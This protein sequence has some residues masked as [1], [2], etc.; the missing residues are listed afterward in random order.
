MNCISPEKYTVSEQALL[1][2]AE[3]IDHSKR[4]D[5]QKMTDFVVLES[6]Y[7]LS[8]AIRAAQCNEDWVDIEH[9]YHWSFQVQSWYD[10]LAVSLQE[11]DPS[12]SLRKGSSAAQA[13]ATVEPLVRD[14]KQALEVL[15]KGEES[16]RLR[17]TDEY[18]RSVSTRIATRI[19]NLFPSFVWDSRWSLTARPMQVWDWTREC[20]V[21][22]G[23]DIQLAFVP[24][25]E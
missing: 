23:V 22:G 5:V 19:D 10:R 14:Q 15:E 1:E 20:M 24:L 8:E 21:H 4:R 9:T 25:P 18:Y 16:S 11:L 13:L 6:L 17:W 2:N 7:V 3:I 12:S